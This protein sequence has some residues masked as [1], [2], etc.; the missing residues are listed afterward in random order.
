MAKNRKKDSERISGWRALGEA[1]LNLSP[2]E[3]PLGLVLLATCALIWIMM[4]YCAEW[5]WLMAGVIVGV[6]LV[7]VLAMR[8][9][10]AHIRDG[11]KGSTET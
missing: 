5:P 4:S 8:W 11:T 1:I 10:F 9:A 6:F 3:R 7:I 2:S